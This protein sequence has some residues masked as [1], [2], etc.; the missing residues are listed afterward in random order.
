MV[1]LVCVSDVCLCSSQRTKLA[2]ATWWHFCFTAVRYRDYS[3]YTH[4]TLCWVH[5]FTWQQPSAFRHGQDDLLRRQMKIKRK[6]ILSAADN[7]RLQG[8]GSQMDA[9]SWYIHSFIITFLIKLKMVV[10]FMMVVDKGKK[11][12]FVR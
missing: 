10:I 5:L 8:N 7:L 11:G 2:N 9:Q 3:D 4:L 6:V 1:W 12:Y